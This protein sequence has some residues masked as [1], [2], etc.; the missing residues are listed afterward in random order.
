MTVSYFEWV[1][2]LARIRFG[3][4]HKREEENK[5][6]KILLALEKITDTAKPFSLSPLTIQNYEIE[7][8]VK[9]F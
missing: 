3:R 1:K 5:M 6:E 9:T 8:C 2:N 7:Q 4:L